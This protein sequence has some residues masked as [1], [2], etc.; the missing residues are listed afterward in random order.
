MTKRFML[1][2]KPEVSSQDISL[3][4]IFSLSS[5]SLPSIQGY[6][7]PQA[8]NREVSISDPT[9][10]W[11]GSWHQPMGWLSLPATEPKVKRSHAQK[12]WVG[13]FYLWNIRWYMSGRWHWTSACPQGNPRSVWP[14]TVQLS[15]ALASRSLP[16]WSILHAR[17]KMPMGTLSGMST[18]KMVWTWRPQVLQES[19]ARPWNLHTLQH[20]SRKKKHCSTY[21]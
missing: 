5:W 9:Y 3:P 1:K 13:L 14:A 20:S 17:R 19:Q 4:L 2:G 15:T 6:I 18:V 8:L 21:A 11:L 16:S 7:P 12:R 10:T